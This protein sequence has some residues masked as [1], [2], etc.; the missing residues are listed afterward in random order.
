MGQVLAINNLGR[1]AA[2][3][4]DVFHPPIPATVGA[5][6]GYISGTLVT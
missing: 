6:G 4:E 3:V 2:G 5:D 1:A